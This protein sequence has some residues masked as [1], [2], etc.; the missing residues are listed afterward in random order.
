[1]FLIYIVEQWFNSECII[2]FQRQLLV[3]ALKFKIMHHLKEFQHS[4]E[5]TAFKKIENF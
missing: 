2:I 3:V 5:S 4:Y 1:M